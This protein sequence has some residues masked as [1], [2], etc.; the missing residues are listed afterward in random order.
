MQSESMQ[1]ILSLQIFLCFLSILQENVRSGHMEVM[2]TML[3]VFFHS[4]TKEKPITH[5]SPKMTML[6]NGV[7]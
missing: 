1:K 2:A 4:Y 6:I 5:V 3:A 7:L